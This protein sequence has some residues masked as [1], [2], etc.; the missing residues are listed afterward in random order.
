MQLSETFHALPSEG[1]IYD[2]D[3]LDMEVFN[4]ILRHRNDKAKLDADRNKNK[5]KPKGGGR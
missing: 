5:N 1:G 2:Q 4:M 3:F